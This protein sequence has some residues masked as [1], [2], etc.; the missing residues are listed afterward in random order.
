MDN[1]TWVK[2]ESWHWALPGPAPLQ[3][4][5]GRTAA[6]DAPTVDL[7]PAAKSCESCL[8]DYAREHDIPEVSVDVDGAEPTPD[9]VDSSGPVTD[10]VAGGAEAAPAYDE[11]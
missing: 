8:R 4:H 7:L 5:C 9:E 3:T 2:I 10:V 1:A 6:D 11:D